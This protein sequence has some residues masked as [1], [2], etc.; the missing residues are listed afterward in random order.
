MVAMAFIGFI[1]KAEWTP[2][3]N[4]GVNFHQTQNLPVPQYYDNMIPYY[5]SPQI[6]YNTDI[7]VNH[8]MMAQYH[9]LVL[10]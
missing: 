4:H 8:S 7:C 5:G 2:L 9:M 3:Y 1:H 10:R 6:T